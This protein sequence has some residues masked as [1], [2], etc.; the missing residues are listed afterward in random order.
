M[1]DLARPTATAFTAVLSMICAMELKLLP[2]CCRSLHWNDRR[3]RP[4]NSRAA[5]LSGIVSDEDTR[6]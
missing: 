2:L 4:Q 3:P 6:R 1:S 5:P